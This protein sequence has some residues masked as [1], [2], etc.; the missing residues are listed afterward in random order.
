MRDECSL[1][2]LIQS[3]M[4]ACGMVSPTLNE[5]LSCSFSHFGNTQ[6]HTKVCFKTNLNPL[7]LP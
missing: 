4:Q 1:S 5:G 3:R 7:V 2:P 6:T